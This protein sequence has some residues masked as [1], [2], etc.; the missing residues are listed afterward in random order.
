MKS[1]IEREAT[2]EH[3]CGG[4]NSKEHT[5]DYNKCSYFLNLNS[6]CLNTQPGTRIMPQPYFSRAAP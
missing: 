3:L 1:I 2:L 4:H 6:N 5:N